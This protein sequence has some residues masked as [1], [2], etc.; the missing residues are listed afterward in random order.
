[1]EATTDESLSELSNPKLLENI[2]GVLASLLGCYIDNTFIGEKSYKVDHSNSNF[3]DNFLNTDDPMMTMVES[4]NNSRRNSTQSTAV[5][6]NIPYETSERDLFLLLLLLDHQQMAVKTWTVSHDHIGS[7]LMAAIFLRNLSREASSLDMMDLALIYKE[8]SS[9]WQDR[10]ISLLNSCYEMDPLR[11]NRL[12]SRSLFMWQGLTILEM[13]YYGDK[14]R[15][16]EHAAI[17]TKLSQLWIGRMATFTKQSL[18]YSAIF[19][20]LLPFLIFRIRFIQST[21]KQIDLVDEI[22]EKVSPTTYLNQESKKKISGIVE[23]TPCT[24]ICFGRIAPETIGYNNKELNTTG[25]LKSVTSGHDDKKLLRASIFNTSRDTRISVF[26]AIYFLY[27]SPLVKFVTHSLALLI[28]L[29]LFSAFV[30]IGIEPNHFSWLEIYIWYCSLL[31][32]IDLLREGFSDRSLRF[33]ERA[34]AFFRDTWKVSDLFAFILLLIALILHCVLPPS[35][36]VYP[37]TIYAICCVVY[38]VKSLH[39][40][41]VTKALGPRVAGLF[42]MLPD[43]A[44]FVLMYL[45]ILL[46]FSMPIY[47]LTNPNTTFNSLE[48]FLGAMVSVAYSQMWS[49]FITSMTETRQTVEGTCSSLSI[50]DDLFRSINSTLKSATT[51]T[52]TEKPTSSIAEFVKFNLTNGSIL[53]PPPGPGAITY[54]PLYNCSQRNIIAVV[55]YVI[56]LLLTNI[57]LFSLLIAMFC[58]FSPSICCLFLKLFFLCLF[59][60]LIR[61]DK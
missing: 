6:M 31:Y 61:W 8:R 32:F 46:A 57:V 51:T 16:M 5:R 20:P 48:D 7:A 25:N 11:C 27:S 2:G 36:F 45:I 30:L 34:I 44:F 42:T 55:L 41:Y 56:F 28:F 50:M 53:E 37:I 59:M 10:A 38:W 21:V 58:K 39:V 26:T 23:A 52:T 49:L 54:T 9:R 24:R 3:A 17:Q 15:I 12:L 43:V 4:R 18:I 19:P 33:S 1:M 35:K 40:F 13:A 60:Q 22:Y 47:S 14:K 29:L